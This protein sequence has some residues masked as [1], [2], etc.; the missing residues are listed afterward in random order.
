MIR[1][2]MRADSFV[3]STCSGGLQIELCV[4]T[5]SFV[6]RDDKLSVGLFPA[7]DSIKRRARHHKAGTGSLVQ[8]FMITYR[9]GFAPS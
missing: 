1:G 9:L 2:S 3:Y 6:H 8:V 4:H 7:V 5:W